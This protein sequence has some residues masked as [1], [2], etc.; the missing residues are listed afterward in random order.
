MQYIRKINWSGEGNSSSTKS[1][2]AYWVA[3]IQK[4]RLLDN[5]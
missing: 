2:F 1:Q 3:N 5:E 4:H